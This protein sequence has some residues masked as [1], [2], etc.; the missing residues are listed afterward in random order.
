MRD[1]IDQVGTDRPN[2]PARGGV[3]PLAVIRSHI[4]GLEGIF[5]EIAKWF[6]RLPP[7]ALRAKEMSSGEI[8]RCL[9]TSRTTV[10]RF[11]RE[12]GYEGFTDFKVAWAQSESGTK[13]ESKDGSAAERRNRVYDLTV[14][15]MADTMRALDREAFERAVNALC[16]ASNVVWYG[17][18]E[19]THI[20]GCG[21]HK[22]ALSGK[23]GQV[24]QSSSSL[25]LLIHS[26]NAGDV[27]IVVSQSGRWDNVAR[28]LAPFQAKGCYV[29]GITSRATSVI[30]N[31][32]DLVLLTHA[33]DRKSVV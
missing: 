16:H 31:A 4:D 32:A 7:G 9:N 18:G 11:C 28:N 19:S 10:V 8:A 1:V 13:I 29:I 17:V 25:R 21:A 15:S 20:A 6:L 24:I 33:R 2:V 3:S 27:I 23:R 30:A 14:Q 5:L 12:L 26:V 22:M